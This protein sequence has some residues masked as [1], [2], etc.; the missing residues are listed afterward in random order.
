MPRI[1]DHAERRGQIADAV[2][3]LIAAESLDSVTVARTAEEAGISVG[4]VQHYFA[5]KDEMLL[6][7]FR[8]IRNRIEARVAARRQRSERAGAR[9]ERMLLDGVAE[10]MPLDPARRSE[11]WVTLAFTA[12]SFSN[13]ALADV[14]RSSN[15]NLRAQIEQ[16]L[17][18]ALACGE[19]PEPV[20]Y[21][22]EAARLLAFVD[23]LVLHCHTGQRPLSARAAHAMVAAELAR[24]LPGPCDRSA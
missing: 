20:G 18:N 22:M 21:E 23:G 8:R 5:S 16:A 3:R 10:L 15:A 19:L 7:S 6:E 14:L 2:E 1:V 13:P 9:I 11:G 17:R 24:L 12:R 4:L